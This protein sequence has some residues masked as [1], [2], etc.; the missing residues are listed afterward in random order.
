MTAIRLLGLLAATSIVGGCATTA[1]DK[2]DVTPTAATAPTGS[3]TLTAADGSA[4]GTATLVSEDGKLELRVSAQGLSE[5]VHGIHLHAVGTCTVPDFASAGPHLNPHARM[6]GADNPQGSH[7]GDLPNLTAA[8][9]GTATLTATLAGAPAEV[10]A[11]LFD[12]DGTAVVV[13]AGPDD[14]KT[15]PSGNSGGRIACGVLTRG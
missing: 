9:D 7:L 6:H 11:Q 12:T 2:A 15:D 10:E 1:S 4:R 13:H 3:A 5:G 8:A 14:Y